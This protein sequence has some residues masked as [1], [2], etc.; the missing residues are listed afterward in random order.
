MTNNHFLFVIPP[1]KG[2]CLHS[3]VQTA[4]CPDQQITLCG[5]VDYKQKMI[6]GHTDMNIWDVYG[7]DSYYRDVIEKQNMGVYPPLCQKCNEYEYYLDEQNQIQKH[8][9]KIKFLGWI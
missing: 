8:V 4:V 9:D 6:I 7:P 5:L 2:V 1:K 3:I